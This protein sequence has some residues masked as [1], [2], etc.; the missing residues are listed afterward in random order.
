[1]FTAVSQRGAS[2]GTDMWPPKDYQSWPPSDRMAH[3]SQNG[4]ISSQHSHSSVSGT[5]NSGAQRYKFTGTTSSTAT[6]INSHSQERFGRGQHIRSQ[7]SVS[8]GSLLGTPPPGVTTRVPSL[9]VMQPGPPGMGPTVQPPSF[10]PR[11]QSPMMPP[12][13]S[14]FPGPRVSASGSQSSEASCSVLPPH[15]MSGM[16]Q[17]SHFQQ[18]HPAQEL[19]HQPHSPHF[20]PPSQ[21]IPSRAQSSKHNPMLPPHPQHM[22]PPP[23]IPQ[24]RP[25]VIG[26][27]YVGNRPMGPG[28]N[29]AAPYSGHTQQQFGGAPRFTCGPVRSFRPPW[30]GNQS[31]H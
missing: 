28:F 12:Y 16:P 21:S 19:W 25:D 30:G 15:V 31:Y 13:G 9:S 22:R 29:S 1:M 23:L 5:D 26:I 20:N 17:D 7:I 24:M 14:P 18:C 3:T 11:H 2:S 27:P 6:F 4:I 8:S 10:L